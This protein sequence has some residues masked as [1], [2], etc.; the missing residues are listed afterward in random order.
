MSIGLSVRLLPGQPSPEAVAELREAAEFYLR[1][2]SVE[3]PIEFFHSVFAA[4]RGVEAGTLWSILEQD[5]AVFSRV[6]SDL[7][8]LKPADWVEQHVA[9]LVEAGA[10]CADCP[11]QALCA[12]YFKVPSADY[13]CAGVK[14]VFA[15]L[16]GAAAEIAQDL[17][18]C[19][20]ATP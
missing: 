18:V 4:M 16:A 3:A 13:D 2:P 8:P 9:A 7:E 20:D 11:W 19:S 10:E 12:G 14:E 17:A 1:D 5:P 6:G 15:G